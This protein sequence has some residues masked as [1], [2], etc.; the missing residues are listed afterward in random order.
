LTWSQSLDEMVGE[1]AAAS[2]S[3]KNNLVEMAAS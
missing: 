2:L 3:G 1:T